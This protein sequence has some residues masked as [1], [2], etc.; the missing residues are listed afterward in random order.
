MV[1]F[2]KKYRQNLIK[3]HPKTHQI[4]PFKKIFS[5]VHAPEPP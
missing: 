4:A 2:E 5:G 1:I 3:I